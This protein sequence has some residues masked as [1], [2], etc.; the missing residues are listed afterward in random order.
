MQISFKFMYKKIAAVT[1]VMILTTFDIHIYVYDFL[2]HLN[3]T[4]INWRKRFTQISDLKSVTILKQ[5]L[6]NILQKI[7]MPNFVI[8]KEL[9]T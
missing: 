1:L 5:K 7:K 8:L 6:L 4:T 3:K 2:K 9:R